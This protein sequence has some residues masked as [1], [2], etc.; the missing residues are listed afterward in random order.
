[1]ARAFFV[2]APG[3]GIVI[4]CE[5]FMKP[6]FSRFVARMVLFAVAW[7]AP[8]GFAQWYA[9]ET[10]YHDPVQRVF[11]VEL[12]RVLAW[13]EN[14]AHGAGIAEV[15]YDLNCAED[16]AAEWTLRWLDANG[17][18]WREAKVGYRAAL[19]LG[20]PDFYRNIARQLRAQPWAAFER[21]SETGLEA[22]FWAGLWQMQTSRMAGLRVAMK[23]ES[24]VRENPSDATA[25]ARLAGGLLASTVPSAAGMLTL[26]STLAARGAAWLA[27]A[28]E[29]AGDRGASPAGD[30]R[31][32]VVLKLAQREEQ[33]A[34]LEINTRPD[35]VAAAPDDEAALARDLWR[36]LLGWNERRALLLRAARCETPAH[37]AP[38][39]AAAARLG[40]SGRVVAN[41]AEWLYAGGGEWARLVEMHDYAPLAGV[42]GAHWTSLLWEGASR[43]GWV[44]ALRTLPPAERAKIPGLDAALAGALLPPAMDGEA[45]RER[46]AAAFMAERNNN[47]GNA[48]DDFLD[49]ALPGFRLSAPLMQ[50]A[51]REGGAA[52]PLAPAAA[53][54][55]RDLLNFGWEMC[56][57]Q[58]ASRLRA[59]PAAPSR[60]ALRKA[61]LRH[62]PELSPFLARGVLQKETPGMDH[63]GRFAR[64]DAMA[65]ALLP[66][67]AP[68]EKIVRARQVA[69]RGWLMPGHTRRALHAMLEAGEDVD[70]TVALARRAHAEGG[71][72]LDRAL[73]QT[74][75]QR[76]EFKRMLGER[77]D[78][79]ALLLPSGED[80]SPARAGDTAHQK[81]DRSAGGGARRNASTL[82]KMERAFWS[83]PDIE[84]ARGFFNSCLGLNAPRPALRFAEEAWPLV[85]D[86]KD[87]AAFA[88]TVFT[89]AL[90]EDDTDAARRWLDRAGTGGEGMRRAACAL[91][92]AVAG[93]DDG[94][95]RQAAAALADTP[96]KAAGYTR[97]L[98]RWQ[99]LRRGGEDARARA[100]AELSAQRNLSLFKW[101]VARQ[102]NLGDERRIALFGGKNA[103]G[104]DHVLVRCLQEKEK[105]GSRARLGGLDGFSP[106]ER[107]LVQRARARTSP[108]QPLGDE[109]V[110]SQRP[111]NPPEPLRRALLAERGRWLEEAFERECL[112]LRTADEWWA[113]CEEWRKRHAGA[114]EIP[115]RL[116]DRRAALLRLFVRRHPGDAR[117][118]DARLELARGGAPEAA[119]A[120]LAAKPDAPR[121]I[122]AAAMR[123][124]LALRHPPNA[125]PTMEAIFAHQKWLSEFP[126]EKGEAL[127]VDRLFGVL[128]HMPKE[129]AVN[130]ARELADHP[131]TMA[132]ARA[133]AW[134][135]AQTLFERPLDFSFTAVDGRVVDVSH[136]RGSVVLVVFA[137]TWTRD[138]IDAIPPLRG[139]EAAYGGGA[140]DP[141]AARVSPRFRVIGVTFARDG[142]AARAF[143][144]SHGFRWPQYS[145]KGMPKI[146]SW[147]G[148]LPAVPGY[149]L[150]DKHGVPRKVPLDANL[151][152]EI[153]RLLAEPFSASASP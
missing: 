88:G 53:A 31:W 148:H 131:G 46:A 144:A 34:R 51:W 6:R 94:A 64:V 35:A 22:A 77:F 48:D 27:L 9:P 11:P 44:R 32:A 8:N 82:Q 90:V 67:S 136:M 13:R 2:R 14:T 40:E 58:L 72:A 104:A 97:L 139:L 108:R 138:C 142:D 80:A 99:E 23:E 125:A 135:E 81:A 24:A 54:T 113:F 29:E 105:P 26:D 110:P 42:A 79:L 93:Q 140:D 69:R 150:V 92:F 52:S 75:E 7:L 39:L 85:E 137:N 16:G 134:L 65:D 103:R 145:E 43:A 70:G 152:T 12:A 116:A 63:P 132:A 73:R 25:A 37:G 124:L 18:V 86:D 87:A 68:D 36:D 71:M 20:G 128:A 98:D 127:V 47:N 102:L 50:L 121:T 141:G 149:W 96:D 118:W 84:R 10:N 33:A 59:A 119:L 3:R 91:Y 21:M 117:V 56:G 109:D 151:E 153:R 133:G 126:G 61:I 38:L 114:G 62:A 112:G 78:A 115:E 74:L 1:M 49:R 83:R 4:G 143:A 60:E 76:P 130:I 111:E 5:S 45:L 100:F 66:P 147:M 101:I 41:A 30:L 28:E 146:H 107:V 89:L 55:A 129:A 95:A 106:E 15:T 122:R 123:E 19:L 120:E 17:G 57:A